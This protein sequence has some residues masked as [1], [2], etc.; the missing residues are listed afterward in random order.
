MKRPVGVLALVLGIG[1]ATFAPDPSAVRAD[2]GGS[3]IGSMPTCERPVDP[4]RCTSVGNDR[5]HYIYIDASVPADLADAIRQAMG[6]YD[7]TYLVVVE[8]PR[9]TD[10]TDAIAY[11]SDAGQNGAAGWVY[12]PPDAPQGLNGFGHRWCRHQEIHFNLNSRYH[13][14]F[15]DGASRLSLACH[16]MGH[17]IGL[18]HWGNPPRSMGP[19][20]RTCM[21]PDVP[22]GPTDL[23]RRDRDHIDAYYA[24]AD[25]APAHPDTRRIRRGAAYDADARSHLR[26]DVP[27]PP[28]REG[29]WSASIR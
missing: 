27:R 16:E 5:W 10:A 12:C 6:V 9:I 20:A 11:A 28:E 18:R 1:L 2:H 13:A 21:Q 14:F 29:W 17:T 26:G 19:A 8:Q 22:D 23:D 7:G 24:A 3:P 4:P 15:A 25:A